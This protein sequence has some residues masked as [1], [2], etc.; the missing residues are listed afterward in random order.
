[1]LLSFIIPVHNSS[2]TLSRCLDSLLSQPIQNFEIILVFNNST[3]NSLKIAQEYVKNHQ[4]IKLFTHNTPGAAAARN[5]GFTKSTGK[6]IWFIDADDYIAPNA[7]KLLLDN[8]SRSDLITFQAAKLHQDG[9][10][11]Y[12]PALNPTASDF[13]SRFVRY[14]FGPWHFLIRRSFWQQNHLKFKAGIIH[15]DM[16]IMSSL[17]LFTDHIAS[18][19]QTL[20]YYIE[21]SGSVLHQN[22]N[23]HYFDIFPALESLYQR[24][25]AHHAIDT[26]HDELEY[27]F[28]WNLLLDSAHDFKKSPAGRPGFAKTRQIL[29]KY[30]PTWR[31]NRFLCQKT[32]SF[33]LRCRLSYHGIVI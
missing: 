5:F 27:F 7:A 14:G 16:E 28:I 3:D 21:T 26:Y 19:D 6:F 31:K 13:K 8:S 2:A 30:F 15:E 4:N 17:I 12:L 18:V 29:Q 25:L 32:F 10:I 1:M 11:S 9:T 24:F 33:R 22:W 23:I 20:Y